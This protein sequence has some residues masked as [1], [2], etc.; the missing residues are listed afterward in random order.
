MS[1]AAPQG[2]ADAVAVVG[3]L[4]LGNHRLTVTLFAA[5]ASRPDVDTMA[6]FQGGFDSHFSAFTALTDLGRVLE[7]FA[8][9]GGTVP[10]GQP[11]S[12]AA[13]RARIT[14]L[15]SELADL[16][17][18]TDRPP[19]LPHHHPGSRH[20]STPPPPPPPPPVRPPEGSTLPVTHTASQNTAI[21]SAAVE[22]DVLGPITHLPYVVARFAEAGSMDAMSTLQAA[23]HLTTMAG[24]AGQAA[25]AFLFSSGACTKK[26][27]SGIAAVVH[28]L[29]DRI[30]H[31]VDELAKKALGGTASLTMGGMGLR[32]SIQEQTVTFAFDPSTCIRIFAAHPST[33]VEAA[34]HVTAHDGVLGDP[35][36]SKD[37]LNG[38]KEYEAMVLAPLW[39]G[40]GRIAMLPATDHASQGAFGLTGLVSHCNEAGLEA[41]QTIEVLL[42]TSGEIFNAGA[43]RRRTKGARVAP[44][45]TIVGRNRAVRVDATAV[46]DAA[47]SEGARGYRDERERDRD[48]YRLGAD[49]DPYSSPRDQALQLARPTSAAGFVAGE[50]TR[51]V[52]SFGRR[53]ASGALQPLAGR[54]ARSEGLRGRSRS[55]SRER[56]RSQARDEGASPRRDARDSMPANRLRLGAGTPEADSEVRAVLAAQGGARSPSRLRDTSSLDGRDRHRERGSTPD[57]RQRDERRPDDRHADGRRSV[58]RSPARGLGRED[59]R[60]PA[61]GRGG[62]LDGTAEAPFTHRAGMARAFRIR[63]KAA[64]APSTCPFMA[65]GGQCANTECDNCRSDAKYD[66]RVHAQIVRETKAAASSDFASSFRWRVVG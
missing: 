22:R 25:H 30:R 51:A 52:P 45:V 17:R 19:T 13:A 58:S 27:T 10:R 32:S 11:A 28:D 53:P 24:G 4:G 31:Y 61:P 7:D 29:H 43:E 6:A 44:V 47:R 12:T 16:R 64:G 8:S 39:G 37:I 35:T 26:L 46:R 40:P 65:C 60:S 55:P 5:M 62:A 63:C 15:Q 42:K 38:I 50:D 56:S 41:A 21:R 20:A 34:T 9:L 1:F 59:E 18:L 3:D 49:R 48:R 57:S 14:V 54:P 66:P 2:L 36:A 33:A 23:E